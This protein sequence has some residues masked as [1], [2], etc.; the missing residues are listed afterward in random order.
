MEKIRMR[1]VALLAVGFASTCWRWTEMR[2]KPSINV[3]VGGQ[4]CTGNGKWT[5]KDFRTVAKV[6]L[7]AADALESK[8]HGCIEDDEETAS[9][10]LDFGGPFTEKE[11]LPRI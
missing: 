3:S 6:F 9:I 1:H 11:G 8:R 5:A 7:R 2:K 10:G 4:D